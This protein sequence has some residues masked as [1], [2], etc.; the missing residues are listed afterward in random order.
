MEKLQQRGEM[1][2]LRP[3]KET[4]SGAGVAVGS[5]GIGAPQPASDGSAWEHRAALGTLSPF[6]GL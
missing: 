1:L 5:F 6:R 3:Q 4:V 2:C